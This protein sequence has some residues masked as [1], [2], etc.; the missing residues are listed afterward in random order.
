MEILGDSGGDAGPFFG[1]GEDSIG[2][3]CQIWLSSEKRGG[4]ILGEARKLSVEVLIG[5][6]SY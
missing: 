5:S 3:I 2:G 1:G 6:G 4:G